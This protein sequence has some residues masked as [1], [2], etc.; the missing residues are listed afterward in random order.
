[1]LAWAPSLPAQPRPH[2][3]LILGARVLDGA[4]NPWLRQDVAVRGDRI[5]FVG[6]AASS[7]V[8]ARDTVRADGLYLSPGFI[9]AHS[10]AE[11]DADYGRDALPFLYQGITTVVIG[12]DGGGTNEVAKAFA[13]YRRRGIGVNAAVFVGHGAARQQV[14]GPVD[15]VPTADEMARMQAYVRQGMREGALGL[16]T[17][18]FYSPGT[19]AKTAEVIALNRVAAEFGGVYDTH[20][21][22]LGA[23]YGGI[24]FEASMREAIEIGEKGGTPVIFSHLS[25]QGQHNYGRADVAIRLIEEARARG[26]NV[27]A[28]QHPYTATQSNLRS[29]T[30]PD[31]A[32]VGGH[33]KMLERFRDPAIV[34]RLDDESARMIAFRGGP[35]KILIVD[36][37]PDI[38][39]KTV[40]D[41]AARLGV[42]PAQAVRRVLEGGNAA[43]MNLDLYDL[44]NIR[45]LAK[46]EWMMTCTDGR[47]PPPGAEVTHPRPYGA[48]TRKLRMLVREESVISLPFAVRGM[49]SLAASFLGLGERGLVRE[50]YYADLVVFDFDR[51]NDPATIEEPRRFAEGV[52]WVMVNGR[53]AIREGRATGIL[54]GI[55]I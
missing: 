22:D 29:Y 48:F 21:R 32:F 36:A 3:V 35:E 30:I 8:R 5:S 27:M 16:S 38:N 33:A 17:G 46:Q 45:L 47:S 2:D 52:R 20:D 34:A 44:G 9:D 54:G 4:G 24:G 28:A 40:A 10:H 43:V 14:M 50:G 18:L 55:G 13:E 49:T 7:G 31:W 23:V 39:G 42:T 6:H 11:L 15:R 12:V 25:P 51:L 37:R 41:I 26:V 19:Y 1:L 53:W